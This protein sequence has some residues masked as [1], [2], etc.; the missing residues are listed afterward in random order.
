MS[1]YEDIW[2]I[3]AGI[4]LFKFSNG[5]DRICEICPNLTIKTSGRS[6]WCSSGAFINFNRFHISLRCFHCW[7]WT[8]LWWYIKN[9][10]SIQ[11]LRLQASDFVGYGFPVDM[12]KLLCLMGS[13][14]SVTFAIHDW[15]DLHEKILAWSVFRRLRFFVNDKLTVSLQL[16]CSKKGRFYCRLVV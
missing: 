12:P 7:L 14:N 4:Y 6:H 10:V 11:K 15:Y 16:E 2:G 3:P 8:R 13:C 9:W 1:N 5:N